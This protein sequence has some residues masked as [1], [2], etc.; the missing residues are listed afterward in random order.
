MQEMRVAL[1]G[2][3]FNPPHLGHQLVALTV[4]ETHPV[5][6]L[7]MV[8]CF[9]HPFDKA[10]APYADRLAMCGLAARALGPRVRV[11]D[12]EGRLGGESRTL[13]T[14]QALLRE[15]P[16]LEIQL[17][18]GADLVNEVATWYGADE[19]QR[20]VS[21]VVVGR[22]G[23]PGPGGVAMPAISSTDVRARLAAG[24]SVDALL[25]RVVLDYVRERKLYGA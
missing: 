17:V 16:S 2:G 25:P 13:L 18:V 15:E 3:S 5:D 12:V 6:A 1:F 7:W 20:L 24:D 11:S 23:A 9:K 19:L 22:A 10:L 8:P 4:L 21:F 14:V